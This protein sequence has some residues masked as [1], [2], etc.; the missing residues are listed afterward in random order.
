MLEN[1]LQ[2]CSGHFAPRDYRNIAIACMELRIKQAM[3]RHA[4]A[5]HAVF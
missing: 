2:A 5:M 4:G 1:Q 3:G